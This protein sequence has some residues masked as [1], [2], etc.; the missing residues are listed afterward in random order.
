MQHELQNGKHVGIR[1]LEKEDLPAIMQLQSIVIEDLIDK[2]RLEPLS[3]EEFLSI[4]NGDNLMIGVFDGDVLIGFRA[5]MIPEKDDEGLGSDIGLTEKDY[6]QIVYSEISNVHPE[7]RGNGLQ[8][9]MGKQ[10]I[11]SLDKNQFRYILATVAPFNI[12]SLKD[13][14]ALGMKIYRMKDKYGGKLRYVFCKDVQEMHTDSDSIIEIDMANTKKQQH[15]LEVGYVG[16]RLMEKDNTWYVV[17][18]K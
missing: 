1:Y 9:F 10:W 2:D 11:E 14:F 3:E 16:T 7:Y 6:D 5:F 4:L 8:S 15:Y 13:K 18:E 17:Y 12:A